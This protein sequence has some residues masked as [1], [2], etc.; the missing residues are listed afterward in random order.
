MLAFSQF[1][2]RRYRMLP[3]REGYRGWVSSYE[4]TVEDEMDVV[5]LEGLESV[6]WSEIH[7]AIDLGCGTG[8]TGAWIR[9]HGIPRIDGGDLTPE[10]IDVA[11]RRDVYDELRIADVSATGLDE[12]AY[13][14]AV[15]C[16]VD[17]HLPD[18][19]PLYRE[20]SRLVRRRGYHVLV[21]YHP[22]F[23]MASGMPAHFD[24]ATG[25]PVA[26]ETYVHLVSDHVGAAREAGWSLVEMR[27]RL[28]DDRWIALKPQWA[29][30]RNVPVSFAMAWRKGE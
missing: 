16:L 29:D 22:Y 6:P 7:R 9:A 12:G 13:D 26:I 27:E 21:G 30:Y 18:V 2:K 8:R 4:D 23:M 3:V 24:T 5:L 17:E 14:L 11:R 20:A 1:D 15:A 28:V 25:E 19:R 10:M